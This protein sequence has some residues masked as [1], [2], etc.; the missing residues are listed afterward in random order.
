MEEVDL[1]VEVNCA[2]DLKQLCQTKAKITQLPINAVKSTVIG[3]GGSAEVCLL[4]C[5]IQVP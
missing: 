2:E 5:V 3:E 4:R 1:G